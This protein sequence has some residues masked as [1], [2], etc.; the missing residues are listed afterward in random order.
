[1]TRLCDGAPGNK[2]CPRRNPCE[3]D[4]HFNTAV[5]QSAEIEATAHWEGIQ[6]QLVWAS[7]AFV[8]IVGCTLMGAVVYFVLGVV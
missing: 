7:W 4:C 1:M 8:A 2:P 3:G 5:V 6:R